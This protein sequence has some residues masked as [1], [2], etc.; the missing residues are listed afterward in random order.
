[1]RKDIQNYLANRPDLKQFMREQPIWY[2][3]LSRN[4]SAIQSMEQ[5]ANVYYGRTF[6]QRIE[7]LQNNINLTMML[8]E[9]V[10]NMNIIDP[11]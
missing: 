4:P 2:R 6:P 9:M 8:L 10:R 1:M 5:Q 7:R 3:R 11:S